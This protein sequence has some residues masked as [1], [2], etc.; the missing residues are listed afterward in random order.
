[1]TARAICFDLDD[2]LYDYQQYSRAGLQSA[3]DRLETLTG[4]RYHGELEAMYFQEGMTDGTFDQLLE[5]YDLPAHLLDELIEAFHDATD[6]LT[7][8]P[9]VRRVL[10]DLSDTY[11]TGLVTDGRGGHAKLRRLGLDG[12]FDAVLVTPTIGTSKRESDPFE[13]VLAELSTPPE[14]AVYVGDDPR[15]DFPVPNDLGITTIRLRRG[16][17]IER[18]PETELAI[19]DHEIADLD[20]IKDSLRESTSESA[21]D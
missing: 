10:S 7:P 14:D 20:G 19:P 1:M 8:Y 16:R 17:Q 18:E 3:A 11:R 13:I 15:F 9:E 12:Y 5:R 2:T 6:P 21:T 4:E